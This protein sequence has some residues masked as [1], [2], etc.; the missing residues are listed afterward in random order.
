M[1]SLTETAQGN[2]GCYKAHVYYVIVSILNINQRQ[3]ILS[4][5]VNR[6]GH[7]YPV[8]AANQLAKAQHVVA[9]RRRL[10]VGG[11]LSTAGIGAGHAWRCKPSDRISLGLFTIAPDSIMK[12]SAIL[13]ATHRASHKRRV[14]TEKKIAESHLT[15]SHAAC[16]F[17]IVMARAFCWHTLGYINPDGVVVSL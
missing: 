4:G 13:R 10:V 2:S 8:V 9:S 16:T 11:V 3:A 14:A 17:I 7:S 5:K 1:Y 15:C 6:G 12:S